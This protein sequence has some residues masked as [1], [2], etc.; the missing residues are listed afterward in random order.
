V[1]EDVLRLDVAVENALLV[2]VLAPLGHLHK[3]VQRLSFGQAPLLLDQVVQGT[4]SAA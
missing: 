1:N 4:M 3:Q 2:E